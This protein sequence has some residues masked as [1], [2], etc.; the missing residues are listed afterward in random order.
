VSTIKVSSIKNASTD[1]GGI[2]IDGTGHVQVD[3]VQMPTAGALSHRNLVINGGMQVSQRT[4]SETGITTNKYSACDRFKTYPVNLGTWT[5]SQETSGFSDTWEAGSTE[6]FRTYLKVTCTTADASPAAADQMFVLYSVESQD[7]RC[8]HYGT[9][10]A[11]PSILSFWVKSNKTGNA[12]IDILQYQNSSRQLAIQYTINAADTWEYKTISLPADTSGSFDYDNGI[13]F[14]IYWHLNSGSNVTGGSHSTTW[15]TYDAT[16]SNAS[17]LGVGGTT[18]DYFA[19]TGVQLEVGEKAT[20]FEHRSYGDE[21]TRCERYYQTSSPR[22]QSAQYLITD[23]ICSQFV[24][25]NPEMRATPSPTY[26]SLSYRE[27]S[28]SFTNSTLSS[29][30]S[31]DKYGINFVMD[32]T[33]AA[34][35]DSFV[36]YMTGGEFDAEL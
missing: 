23:E 35:S 22:Y 12:S 31:L 28:G 32:A 34:T 14:Q 8:L 18:S 29:N 7:L 10:Q 13:G 33:G 5:A 11:K 16:S 15:Q 24:P 36:I 26:A 17:N 19:I 4:T 6:R 25:F 9:T 20:P 1:D 21:L 30:A 27:N 2:A 3:G